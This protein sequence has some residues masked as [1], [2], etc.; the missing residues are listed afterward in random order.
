MKKSILYLSVFA[1]GL[2]LASCAEQLDI[3]QKS[4]LDLATYYETAGPEEAEALVARIHKQYFSGVMGIP[5]VCLLDILSDDHLAGGGGGSDNSWN[6][7]DAGNYMM[8]SS[9]YIPNQV[10]TGIYR[11]VYYCNSIIERIPESNDVKIQWAKAE[12]RF[13]RAIAMFEAV[14][15]WGTPPE[16]DHL[17]S[18][19]EYNAPNGDPKKIITWCLENLDDAAAVL[20]PMT[21]DHH[22]FGAYVSKE[23]A[24]A[25]KGKI[26]LWYG[27]KYNDADILKQAIEPLKAVISSGAF[28]LV[29]DMKILGRT[30][31]D[32]CKEYVFEHN[33]ADNDGYVDTNQTDL[34]HTYLGLRVEQLAL[35]K[36]I[37]GG[38]WGWVGVSGDFGEFLTEHDGIDGKRFQAWICNYDQI[39][40]MEY[41]EN[42]KPEDL[43]IKRAYPDN[44][45]YFR[46]KNIFY[47]NDLYPSNA[48]WK[49]SK[50]NW[51]Y[52][53]YAEVLLLYAEAAFLTGTDVPGG[54]A[55]LNQVRQRAGL[56]ALASMTYQDIK[57]ERRAELFSEQERF[58]DLIRWG[59]APTALKDKGKKL[60]SLAVGGYKPGVTPGGPDSWNVIVDE[61]VG[62]GWNDKYLLL[63]FPYNQI[64]A[65]PNLTQNPGW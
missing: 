63:P 29:D 2:T 53:R 38:G 39:L 55:A 25:Y 52:M 42:L 24:L 14:R 56:P 41:N 26:A 22:A 46:M 16:A 36:H 13:F 62:Y 44:Q 59:E 21:A 33:A 54:L 50:A 64:Q 28:G 7:R 17:L 40:A 47:E 18:E 12:A 10:Y 57:D 49:Y 34:R 11:E 3:P 32:F 37:H 15:W 58:F 20:K 5:T 6:M 9:D 65:N 1:L 4:V 45:G 61:G 51:Y 8:T 31:G 60:Y 19:D 27:Q 48:F 43:G 35:P 30:E 23:A